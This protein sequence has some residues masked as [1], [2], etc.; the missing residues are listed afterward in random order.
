MQIS[1]KQKFD[2]WMFYLELAMSHNFPKAM[3]DSLSDLSSCLAE[4]ARGEDINTAFGLVMTRGRQPN[5]AKDRLW[6]IFIRWFVVAKQ[7]TSLSNEK[8]FYE[9]LT[10]EVKELL[11]ISGNDH[12][13]LDKRLKEHGRDVFLDLEYVAGSLL[14]DEV[15]LIKV[16]ED[17]TLMQPDNESIY[18]T[19]WIESNLLGPFRL[20]WLD[21]QPSRDWQ[22]YHLNWTETSS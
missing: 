17:L 3:I 6:E 20:Q 12:S 11:G 19:L 22:P 18:L 4:V 1:H 8:I 21:V 9:L 5:E 16:L 13:I 2:N 14:N 7:T 10:D 15:E